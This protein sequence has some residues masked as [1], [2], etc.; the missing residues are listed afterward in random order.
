MQMVKPR[1]KGIIVG[2]LYFSQHA[3]HLNTNQ[4]KQVKQKTK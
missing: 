3:I 4:M 1:T 2:A